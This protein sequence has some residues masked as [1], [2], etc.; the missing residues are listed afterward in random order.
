MFLQLWQTQASFEQPSVFFTCWLGVGCQSNFGKEGSQ[1][2]GYLSSGS[3]PAFSRPK[4][5]MNV[6][7]WI[8]YSL[9]PKLLQSCLTLR[10]PVDCSPADFSVHGILQARILE[11]A[12]VSS[13]RGS[14][15]SQGSKPCLLGLLHW[16]VGSLPIRGNLIGVF[17]NVETSQ[18]F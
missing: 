17:P 14:F 11:W 1:R 3:S 12:A 10:N 4:L 9:S 2:A 16:Q 15:P 6:S 18:E 13:P 8:S 7:F 5:I